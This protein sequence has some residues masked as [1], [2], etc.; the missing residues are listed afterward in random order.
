M[1]GKV[2]S[3]SIELVKKKSL[4]FTPTKYEFFYQIEYD[5]TIKCHY[6]AGNELFSR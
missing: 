3:T 6:S 2:V 1:F 4:K 5:F